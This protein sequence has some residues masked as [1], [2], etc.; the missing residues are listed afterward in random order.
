MVCET[1]HFHNPRNTATTTGT[2]RK[3]AAVELKALLGED[4]DKLRRLRLCVNDASIL[5]TDAAYQVRMMEGYSMRDLC[6]PFYNSI[7]LLFAEVDGRSYFS[8][9]LEL[10]PTEFRGLPL[11]LMRPTDEEFAAFGTL[12]SSASQDV[13]RV[14]EAGD[15]GVCE[16]LGIQDLEMRQIRKALRVLRRHRRRHA[17]CA[18]DEGRER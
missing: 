1:H 7:T 10:T 2:K 6:F 11:H 13:T 3:T 12:F 9:V 4:G 5:A 15:Q 18:G 16:E 14:C 8:G 17:N